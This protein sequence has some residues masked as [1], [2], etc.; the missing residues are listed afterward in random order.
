MKRT[1]LDPIRLRWKAAFAGRKSVLRIRAHRDFRFGPLQKILLSV[2]N[3]VL[4]TI[5]TTDLDCLPLFPFCPASHR[6]HLLRSARKSG[7]A[8]VMIRKHCTATSVSAHIMEFFSSITVTEITYS[9][10]QGLGL[11]FFAFQT[12]KQI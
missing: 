11:V 4:G 7:S 9:L 6:L 5:W 2:T 8:Y 12:S 3:V 1:E 10:Q